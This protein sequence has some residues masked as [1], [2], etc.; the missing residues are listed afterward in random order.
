MVMLKLT[1][2]STRNQSGFTIVE[3]LIVIVVIGILAAITIVAYNG[4]QGKAN[5][6]AVKSDLTN[7]ARKITMYEADN[8]AYPNLN[9]LTGDYQLQYSGQSYKGAIFC[10]NATR[11]VLVGL[12]SSG[13]AFAYDTAT[14][15]IDPVPSATNPAACASFGITNSDPSP[16]I[17]TILSS[18]TGAWNASV[19]H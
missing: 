16:S 18:T 13:T 2:M 19:R 9:Q 4:V 1:L 12:S 7:N 8:V 17:Y 3:L 11:V 15:S 6:V 14:G 10:K 5:D